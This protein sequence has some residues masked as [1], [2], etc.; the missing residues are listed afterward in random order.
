MIF[1]DGKS[2]SCAYC[3]RNGRGGCWVG[4]PAGEPTDATAEV[5]ELQKRVG[6]LETCVQTQA[7][8]IATLCS[9]IEA[10]E[11]DCSS[12]IDIR[13]CKCCKSH[14]HLMTT[15]DQYDTLMIRRRAYIA[16]ALACLETQ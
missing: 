1:R 14:L 2:Q 4:N 16:P 8:T 3:R 11:L 10:L 12:W 9:R 5:V 6:M 13:H 15:V 7:E